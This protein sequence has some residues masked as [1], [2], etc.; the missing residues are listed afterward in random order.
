MLCLEPEN[1]TSKVPYACL[2]IIKGEDILGALVI[3]NQHN[4]HPISEQNVQSLRSLLHY[5]SLVIEDIGLLDRLPDV[6][7]LTE[8]LEG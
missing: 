7:K 2:P 4:K 3:A 6:S 8:A 1:G 5:V